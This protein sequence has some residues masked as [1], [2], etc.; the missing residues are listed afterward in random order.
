MK[1]IGFLRI[2]TG[3]ARAVW[4]KVVLAESVN[5][6]EVEGNAYFPPES[7]KREYLRES[8]H[9]TVCPWK[10]TANYYDV[11]ANG[12]TNQN[13]AWYYA[14]PKQAAERIKGYVAFWK[15]IRVEE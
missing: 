7:L 11:L 9:T 2:R 13:A 14:E 10:G 12:L 1:Q 4:G 15:G 6:V 8:A 3:M 5:T